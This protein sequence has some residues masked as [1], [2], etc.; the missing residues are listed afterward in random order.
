MTLRETIGKSK[1]SYLYAW[2]VLRLGS[3]TSFCTHGDS[4]SSNVSLPGRDG[5]KG[6]ARLFSTLEKAYGAKGQDAA[7]RQLAVSGESA[8]AHSYDS[9][10][11]KL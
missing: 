10:S 2:S 9:V 11:K 4:V 6:A 1:I 8:P 7:R 3:E 5:A